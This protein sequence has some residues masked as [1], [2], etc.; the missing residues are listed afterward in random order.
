MKEPLSLRRWRPFLMAAT[1][2]FILFIFTNSL[3][4]AAVSGARSTAVTGRLNE[5]LTALGLQGVFTDF[6]VRKMGHLAEYAALGALLLL[7]LC[8]RTQRPLPHLGW[9][10]FTGL[11]TGAVD[12]T[13]QLFVPGRSG[14]IRDLLIDF[15]GVLLGMAATAL[16]L[17]LSRTTAKHQ[18]MRV[19]R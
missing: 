6:I 2:L 11:L 5:L 17:L 15:S 16:L 14:E 8:S 10:L 4:V 13:I 18:T 9:P 3:Q 12:E 7:T 1:A 19:L